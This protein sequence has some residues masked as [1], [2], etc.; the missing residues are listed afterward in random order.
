MTVM[1]GFPKTQIE[2]R[3]V[4]GL[5][6]TMQLSATAAAR[7]LKKYRHTVLFAITAL[8]IIAIAAA[9]TATKVNSVIA[10]LAEKQL[11]NLA[12]ESTMND[13]VHI[14]SMIT[15]AQGM[16]DMLGTDGGSGAMTSGGTA[17]SESTPLTLDLLVGP[18]GL[19]A[20]Y[21][22]LVEGLGVL[23]SSLFSPGGE[24][25]WS[26]DPQMIGRK[27]P[28]DAEVKAAAAGTISS[29]LVTD[30]EFVREDGTIFTVDAVEIYVP[31]R[32]SPTSPV[33]G[34]LEF[35]REAGTDLSQLVDDTKSTVVWTTVATMAGLFIAL[36]GFVVVSD[37]IIYVS[38]QKRLAMADERLAEHDRA[39]SELEKAQ[40]QI[41]AS[42][43][44]AVIGQMSAGVAHDIRNPLGAIKNA[45]YM[46]N[47]RLNADGVI[48]ANPKLGR[49][50]EIIDQQVG[51]SNRI[52][53]DLMTFAR[54]GSPNLTETRLERVLEECLETMAKNDNVELTLRVAPDLPAVMAD[55]DQLQRIF[56]NLANNAQEAMPNGGRLS[57]TVENVDN[58]VEVVFMDTGEGISDENIGNIFDP[59][60][61]TKTKGTGLGLAVCQEIILK[62]GGTIGVRRNEE[63]SG[64]TIFKVRLPAA[65][66]EAQ[67]EG[68]PRNDQ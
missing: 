18:T 14:V 42:E 38:T 11:I 52:I 28:L 9:V 43:K 17:P 26:T 47:K 54:V 46:L 2:G 5:E 53:S 32:E 23:E 48:D 24:I 15:G 20:Q 60:F 56:L 64:G 19:P 34:V 63:A 61:T 6:Q 27:L 67:A 33:V 22:R 62:H 41:A 55:G 68:G 25:L 44:L 12:E 49:Y 35:Y 59:L 1:V 58:H 51:K 21:G 13:A 36:L 31:L 39:Q 16:S 7:G 4:A 10:S 65:M 50:L 8:L 66:Q 29:E 37:R 30:K 40:L 57:I 3:S 45:G